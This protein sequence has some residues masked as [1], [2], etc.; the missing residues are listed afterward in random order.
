VPRRDLGFYAGEYY[1]LY[2]RGVDRQ[3]VFFH[4]ENYLYFMRLLKQK[5]ARTAIQIIAYC[6][7]PN[8]FHLLV[9]PEHD[10]A[11]AALLTGVCGSYA[12]ALNGQR[13]RTGAL[14][15]GRFRA[16]HVDR[17]AYLAQVAR[18]IHMN[19][20]AAGLVVKPQDWPYSD[21][22]DIVE[23]GYGPSTDNGLLAGLFPGSNAYQRF[24]EGKDDLQ[25][26]G[27]LKLPGS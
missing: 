12:Q 1:H 4:E 20:V 13:G 9:L 24:V 16:V 14:F 26:P 8:H 18:Y 10:N 5:A 7:M 2:N 19:P 21:Y 6:L 17:D 23:G 15:Q 11:V 22:R 27:S 3:P 25:L